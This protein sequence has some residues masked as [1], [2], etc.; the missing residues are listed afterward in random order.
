MYLGVIAD[1]FT[2]GTDI[3]GFL[4]SGG[5]STVQ[6]NGVPDAGFSTTADAVVLSLKSRSCPA[7]EAVSQSLAALEWFRSQKCE[8]FFFK[9]C[10]TFDST[11]EGNIGPV[12][13][14]L[15]KELGENFTI[16]AP[17]LPVN[18]RT[19]YLGYLFVN[20][21]LL[22]E[23][24]MQNHPINPMRD[25]N[26][27]RL[28]EMQA[29][30]KAG[31]VPAGVLDKGAGAVREAFAALEK[32]GVRYGV[33]DTLTEAHLN[34]L[35]EAV[36]DMLLV[37]GGSG[38]AAG[39]A[40][41]LVAQGKLQRKDASAFGAPL[42]GGRSVV[43]SGSC[44]VMTN[45]QVKLYSASAP[46]F[47]LEVERCLSDAPGYAAE[48]AAW[49]DRQPQTKG[50]APLVYATEP[51]EALKD[52]QQRF[53]AREA[54][55]AVENLFAGL[56]ALLKDK[57]FDHYIVAGGETSGTIVQSLGVSAFHI[58]PQIAPG[59]PWV[60]AVNIPL[61]FALKSG[62]FGDER[63]FAVAQGFY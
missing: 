14:A 62:N 37:T 50:A 22:N 49:V 2:G 13:D 48:V 45:K 53:G 9:Y 23:S 34:V 38:L 12:T 5:L 55:D 59:V 54:S 40:H 43:L 8:R 29:A 17:A 21:V 26:L 61:S 31:N 42:P 10:S 44:S 30:G 41:A 60:R 25:A 46:A 32:A 16:I 39:M 36:S 58:G 56:A 51:P 20:G 35:G 24:G 11:A 33:P 19:V 47:H 3:A 63:F 27:M 18:G 6:L 15:L 1:D 4:V 52:I 7:A 28:M 57:G